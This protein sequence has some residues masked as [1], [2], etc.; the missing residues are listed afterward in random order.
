MQT[1]GRRVKYRHNNLLQHVFEGLR[2]LLA[3]REYSIFLQ[4]GLEYVHISPVCYRPLFSSLAHCNESWRRVDV[5]AAEFNTRHKRAQ[6]S[7]LHLL[8]VVVFV[9]LFPVAHTVNSDAA[10]LEA[11]SKHGQ[12]RVL[13]CTPNS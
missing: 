7:N 5:C 4:L 9:L 12:Q 3:V 8:H 1:R 10:L 2:R 11:G 13:T 6:C